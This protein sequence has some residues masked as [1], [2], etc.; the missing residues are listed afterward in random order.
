MKVYFGRINGRANTYE[1][2]IVSAKVLSNLQGYASMR[3]VHG[4]SLHHSGSPKDLP[5]VLGL[6]GSLPQVVPH[7]RHRQGW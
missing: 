4:K 6:S 3:H 2:W 1:I 5:A 7:G